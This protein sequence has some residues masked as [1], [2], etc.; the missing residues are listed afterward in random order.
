M[1]VSKDLSIESNFKIDENYQTV[2]AIYNEIS[3]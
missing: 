2:K 1:W 3:L